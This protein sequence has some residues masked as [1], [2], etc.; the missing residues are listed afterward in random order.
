MAARLAGKGDLWAAFWK[1]RQLIEPVVEQLGS[2][3]MS[4]DLKMQEE[5]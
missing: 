1:R 4:K 2:L 5:I 3:T